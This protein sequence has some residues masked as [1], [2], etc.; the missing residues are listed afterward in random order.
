MRA[1]RDLL[2][3]LL[4]PILA[5][6]GGR[7]ER[8]VSDLLRAEALV[9][10]RPDSALRV[11][12]GVERPAS[13]PEPL[14]ARWALLVTQARDKAFI[15]HTTDSVI[16]RVVA[17]YDRSGDPSQKALA[18]Y[19]LA[20]VNS[21]LR[22]LEP[23]LAAFLRAADH[24][25][26]SADPDLAFR[27][28]TQAGTLY[29][30]QDMEHEAMKAFQR[31][32]EIAKEA[33]DSVDMAFSY[34]NFGR[35]Y[36]LREDWEQASVSY[37]QAIDMAERVQ[38][39]HSLRLAVQELVSVYGRQKRL[40]EALVLAKRL[41]ELL[42]KSGI[43]GNGS[44]YMVI[45]N[46]YR[47]LNRPDSAEYYLTRAIGFGSIYVQCS[48]YHALYYMYSDQGMHKEANRY[49]DLYRAC[50]DSI[51]AMGS[52]SNLY[53]VKERH[54]ERGR[55]AAARKRRF[56]TGAA[57]LGLAILL[58]GVSFLCLRYRNAKR[59]SGQALARS[60]EED[61]ERLE[62]WERET[63]KWQ[64]KYER[65]YERSKARQ[66]ELERYQAE[67]AATPP[68]AT[69]EET[70]AGLRKRPRPL[71]DR[72]REAIGMYMDLA[73][74]G[75]ARRLREENPGL[76]DGDLLVACLVRLDFAV[77]EMAV[78][79]AIDPKSVSKRKQRLRKNLSARLAG[80][81][82]M[83]DYLRKF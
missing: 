41:P 56:W 12:E 8:V 55:Q 35:I 17:Y 19:Y 75:F 36:G 16:N 21:D 39:Y 59:L 78:L 30:R 54:E 44:G 40:E 47:K 73:C 65:E 5:A 10:G 67:A 46:I 7:E 26:P 57:G 1:L 52:P 22:R 50:E 28:L 58:A 34:V 72:E 63:S 2:L 51:K 43:P 25:S 29:A 37:Q 74:R 64:R 15:R 3:I 14:W 31:A 9:S 32:F 49:N 45:G 42:E 53:Q 27:I 23:A 20:R 79:L 81:A 13:L 71:S 48:A 18:Y 80:D 77:G 76:T 68:A 6:C 70:L 62:R 66:K 24:V 83:V 11:L 82:E 38:N 60:R 69:I 4:L 61:R 33:K